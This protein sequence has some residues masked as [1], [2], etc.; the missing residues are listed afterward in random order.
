VIAMLNCFRLT[1]G[2]LLGVLLIA[3]LAIYL[4][5]Y[6]LQY[7]DVWA[8]AKYGEWYWQHRSTPGVEPLSPFTDKEAPFANVAWLSQVTYYGLYEFGATVAGGD[9]ESQLRGGAEALRSFHLLL[10]VARFVLLWLALRR[11]GGSDTWATL[12]V[13]LYMFAVGFGSAVQ[14]PQAFGL[15]FFTATIFALSTPTL[16]RRAMIWLPAMFL[17]WANLHG[18]FMAGLLVLGLHTV[19]RVIE[20][21]ARDCEIHRLAIACVLCGVA[22]FVN[23][24]GPLLIKHLLAFSSHPNLQTMSEWF[25]MRFSAEG[26]GHWPYLM[27]LI[28]LVFVRVLGGRKVGV[29]GWLVAIPFAIW[30]W[31]QA[32]MLLWWWTVAVWL[33]ARLGPGLADRFP[34]LPSLPDRPPTRANAWIATAVIAI[35]V[36]L[37]PPIRSLS[38]G[39]PHDVDHTV[40]AETPWRL[41]L[42]LKAQSA[43]EGRWQPNL[44]AALKAHYPGGKFIGAIFAS[45]TQGDFLIWALPPEIPVMM[46]TH[47]HVFTPEYWNDCV[48]AEIDATGWRELLNKY[49]ANLIVIETETHQEFAAE[50]RTDPNWAIVQDGPQANSSTGILIALRKNPL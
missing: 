23:P 9:A 47:A 36:L 10:L 25:P 45:E 34:T 1:T 35:A 38:P 20:R 28:L 50:V 48:V 49:R 11:F 3:G 14:R 8:H 15:F 44:R 33:L 24:H 42:E 39:L 29:A 16:S 30:P 21:G 7:T 2:Q 32:R 4:S 12:G 43:D 13:F 40:A 5:F 37:F 17:L 18:T 26:G 41:G 22:T 6:P 31:L 19:G 27:S 46:Y